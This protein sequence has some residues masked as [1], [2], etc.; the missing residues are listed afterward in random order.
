ME[1]K[2]HLL[3]G[4]EGITMVKQV[5]CSYANVLQKKGLNNEHFTGF[6]QNISIFSVRS[7]LFYEEKINM[8]LDDLSTKK[9]RKRKEIN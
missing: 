2:S 7:F 1:I 8:K 3:L 9:E 4:R 5:N 6:L